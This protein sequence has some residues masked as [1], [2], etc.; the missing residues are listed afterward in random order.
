[1]TDV[2]G[3]IAARGGSKRIARKNLAKVGGK[4][5]LAYAIEHARSADHVSRVCVST[6]DAEIREIAQ[7]YSGEVPFERPDWLANDT[8]TTNEVILHALDWFDERGETFD[9][10]CSIPVTAPFREPDDIDEAIARLLDSDATSVVGV[11][12]FD[13]PPF[14]ALTTDGSGFLRPY[15]DEVSPWQRTRSQEVP[16]LHRPNGA[17]FA[18]EISPFR[19]CESFYTDRTIGYEMPPE[20]S[21]DI[22]EQIDLRIARALMREEA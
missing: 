7:D 18:A 16:T 12:E 4:P 3:V 2:L 20:R 5:L 21:I 8:A 13:P 10:V 17:V 11:T 14:W 22:D 9:V 15:F 19:E 6:E 1:M